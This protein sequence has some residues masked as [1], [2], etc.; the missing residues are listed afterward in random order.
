MENGRKS[1][2]AVNFLMI[3]ILYIFWSAVKGKKGEKEGKKERTY[4]I[5]NG[6]L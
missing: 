1:L 6:G 2:P 3:Q 4:G 5:G